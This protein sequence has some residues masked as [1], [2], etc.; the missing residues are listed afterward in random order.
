MFQTHSSHHWGKQGLVVLP[1]TDIHTYMYTRRLGIWWDYPWFLYSLL[2]TFDN[3][4]AP[5]P[6]HYRMA[7]ITALLNKTRNL[8]KYRISLHL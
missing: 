6:P 3:F 2:I 5:L 4:T 7:S 8:L 1:S